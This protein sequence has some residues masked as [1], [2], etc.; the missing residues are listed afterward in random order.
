[1]SGRPEVAKDRCHVIE[2]DDRQI[3]INGSKDALEKAVLTSQNDQ[4]DC[5]Q[6]SAHES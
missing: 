5:S 4:A 1:M 6:I 3:R 2:V